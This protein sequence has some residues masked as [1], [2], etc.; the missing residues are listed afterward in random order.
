MNLSYWEKHTWLTN[1][2]V[3]IIGSGIVGLSCAL[4]L[5]QRNPKLKVVVFE[6]GML[7]SGASTKNAG[8][9]CFGSISEIL[10]DLK[11]HTEDEVLNLVQA[12]VN[13]LQLLRTT[14]GD[15]EIDYQQ[16]GGY[17]IFTENDT[18]LAEECIDN[19]PMV[20]NLLKNVFSGQKEVFSIKKQPF[21]FKN[22]QK[23]VIFN[24]F[25][26][27]LDTGKMMKALL[28]ECSEKG[29]LVLNNA[30]IM[31]ISAENDQ[32]SLNLNNTV[33]FSAKKVG[34]ATNGFAKQFLEADLQPARAQVLITYPIPNLKV[35]GTF[36]LD[37]GYYYFRN[38]HDRILFGGGRNLDFSAEQTTQMG[39]TETVQN[40]LERLLKTTIL[41]ETAFTID[42]RW[43][44]IMGVGKQKKPIIREV[45]PNVYCGVRLGGM[46]IAIGSSVGNEL[47]AA[48]ESI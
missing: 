8:F 48:I 25:E 17:E 16:H 15:T 44:G 46:G 36:H 4:T 28:R 23:Q 20:N 26:G 37:R 14:L 9:A 30:E 31:S 19:V 42:S 34:I 10:D 18:E 2:D 32:I 13:G 45:Q 39:L 43:S 41:P 7:P 27:Q 24:R 3:A 29:V 38:I 40:E 47:A 35:K 22:V 6:K 21:S 11:T 1:I 12:R 5:K 33:T